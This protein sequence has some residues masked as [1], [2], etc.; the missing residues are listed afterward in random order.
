MSLCCQSHVQ[1]DQHAH[2]KSA[3]RSW[4]VSG[5]SDLRVY[6]QKEKQTAS[7]MS[8][9][10]ARS[11]APV[12]GLRD[13]HNLRRLGPLEEVPWRKV[14]V[15]PA[16]FMTFLIYISYEMLLT[17]TWFMTD[18]RFKVEPSSHLHWWCL[19]ADSTDCHDTQQSNEAYHRSNCLRW[20]EEIYWRRHQASHDAARALQNGD[21]AHQ[22]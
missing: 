3:V 2:R 4:K 16:S 20:A 22:G 9:Q 8:R 10:G 19:R 5:C 1:S 13:E 12:P 7:R 21:A 6:P 18:C 15:D 17:K 11:C 14:W